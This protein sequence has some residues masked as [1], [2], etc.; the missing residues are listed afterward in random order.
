M[1][2]ILDL[3]YYPSS[4]HDATKGLMVEPASTRDRN[5][6]YFDAGSAHGWLTADAA[7]SLAGWLNRRY[8]LTPYADAKVGETVQIRPEAREEYERAT[9]AEVVRTPDSDDEYYVRLVDGDVV[10]DTLYIHISKVAHA[11]A[12]LPGE[13]KPAEPAPEFAEGT[14]VVITSDDAQNMLGI[15]LGVPKGMPAVV[16]HITGMGSY[17]IR[18]M[19]AGEMV[20]H[21]VRPTDIALTMPTETPAPATPEPFA[22]KRGDEVRLLPG[23]K[24][25]NG[26]AVCLGNATRVRVE[27]DGLDRD[28]DSYVRALDGTERGMTDWVAARYLAPLDTDPAVAWV[29]G[30]VAVVTENNPRDAELYQGD[31]VRV[32]SVHGTDVIVRIVTGRGGAGTWLVRADHLS[33]P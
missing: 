28:G 11:D 26:R 19:R 23:A 18:F 14:P 33:R 21:A 24:L 16:D 30:D 9:R 20:T 7:R 31:R 4:I 22:P 27:R 12:I 32:T 2:D 8:A 10:N 25:S 6:I 1:T 29:V 17:V 3:D 13:D 5:G 15:R